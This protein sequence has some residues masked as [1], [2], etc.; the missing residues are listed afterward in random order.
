MVKVI[1]FFTG[2]F[3]IFASVVI[4]IALLWGAYGLYGLVVGDNYYSA[5]FLDNNQVYFG[6]ISG[7][8]WSYLNL[9]DV[10]YFG[11]DKDGSNPDNIALIKLGSEMHAP[12]D[13]MKINR[14]HILYIEELSDY[15]RV[16]EA[17]NEH[18]NKK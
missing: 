2:I 13:R 6:K 7:S 15:S 10:Y 17:I 14:K 3:K 18:K 9:T 16:V 4:L 12:T 8:I 5:V 11:S 1:N